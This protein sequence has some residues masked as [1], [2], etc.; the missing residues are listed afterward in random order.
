[1]DDD[2]S[3]VTRKIRRA[4]CEPG[5]IVK[6]PILEYFEYIIFPVF[7]IVTITRKEEHGGDL[8]YNDI[9]TIRDDFRDNKLHPEDLKKTLIRLINQRLA[10]IQDMLLNNPTIA[11]L[12]KE[13]KQF[14]D[15]KK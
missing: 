8:I 2:A 9:N 1:M 7:P 14:R 5:N 15:D 6:N 12:N 11:K 13:V 4:F 3:E 10:P